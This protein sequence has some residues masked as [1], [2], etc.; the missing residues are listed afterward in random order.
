MSVSFNLSGTVL[1]ITG[2]AAN[3]TVQL[4]EMRSNPNSNVADLLQVAWSD[5]LGFSDSSGSYLTA[6]LTKIVFNGNGGNDVFKNRFNPTGAPTFPNPWNQRVIPVLFSTLPA[7]EAHGGS[8]NDILYGGP[9]SD[10]LYGDDGKDTLYG[11]YGQDFLE[12]GL[13]DDNLYGGPGNDV[14]EFGNSLLGGAS[15]GLDTIYESANEGDDLIVFAAAGGGAM[16]RAVNVSLGTTQQQVVNECLTLKLSNAAGIENVWGTDYNDVIRGNALNNSISGGGG[17]DTLYGMA[18]HDTLGGDFGDDVLYG[19][20][21]NDALHGGE[22]ADTLV[23][24][25][26]SLSDRLWGD[27]GDDSFWVDKDARGVAE[28]VHDAS[29]FERIYNLHAV[30][31]FAN[32]ADKTL[33]GDA[34]ADPGS[35]VYSDLARTPVG[36]LWYKNFSGQ[37]LFASTGPSPLDVEQGGM[38]DCWLMSALGSAAQANPNS[39]RQTVVSLGDRTFAVELGSSYYRV[40]ADLPTTGQFS[41]T[42]RFANLGQQGCIWVP[43][44]EKAYALHRPVNHSPD[45]TYGILDRGW[46]SEAYE[47]IGASGL[48]RAS[49][50]DGTDALNHIAA[51]LLWG[52]AVA[53]NILNAAP[54]VPLVARHAY[55]AVKV[56]YVLQGT[57]LVPVSVVLRNPWAQDAN[58]HDGVNEELVTVTGLQLVAAMWNPGDGIHSAWV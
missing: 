3:D 23:S 21:G 5:N 54:A 20:E 27:G 9:N 36:N 37:P 50:T 11:N 58:P 32:G 34:I 53:V 33:D 15:L 45:D 13:R 49:F 17:H 52:K 19:G 35:G 57:T 41:N 14:Y 44:V 56:D 55:M 51:E 38:G 31:N 47:A 22:G 18:G 40:D 6:A 10:G 12:G 7:I 48:V 46:P 4:L 1:N 2:D 8:G 39:I 30:Y 43:I 25:D 16:N 42:L 28:T 24:I 26:L 29:T